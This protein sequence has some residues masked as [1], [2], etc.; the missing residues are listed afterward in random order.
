MLRLIA[1]QPMHTAAAVSNGNN[2]T[3]TVSIF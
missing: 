3:T 1:G 2:I